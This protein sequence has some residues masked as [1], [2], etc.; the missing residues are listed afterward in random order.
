VVKRLA[1]HPRWLVRIRVQGGLPF[2]SATLTYRGQTLV[3]NQVL[4]DTGSAGTVFRADRVS[5][6]G[7]QWGLDDPV[8]LISGTG[9][10]EV[11]FIRTVDGLVVDDL[12][13]SDFEIQ[14][15]A[16]EYGFAIEGIIGL[17]F[18]LRTGAIIDLGRLELLPG[19]SAA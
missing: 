19:S 2:V 7:I 8:R 4:L 3:L 1:E 15:G 18:L 9:G 14:V 6:V 17:D 12:R 10:D 11:V 5:A 16:M 13:V